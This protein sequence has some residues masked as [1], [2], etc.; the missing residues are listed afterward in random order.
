MIVA[1]GSD[2]TSVQRT[3]WIR[4]QAS[5]IKPLLSNTWLASRL[6]S[7]RGFR[8]Y[9]HR[10]GCHQK[11]SSGTKE[12]S[13]A[14]TYRKL[15]EALVKS[16]ITNLMR[17]SRQICTSKYQVDK[18]DQRSHWQSLDDHRNRFGLWEKALIIWNNDLSLENM[19]TWNRQRLL[20][21]DETVS[22][23]MIQ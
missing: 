15:S 10:N 20:V 6:R 21:R 13:A 7:Y 18:E 4:P 2:Q 12:L 19:L 22:D 9:N 3:V 8:H 23:S 17:V 16:P 11:W 1:L 5:I 14:K